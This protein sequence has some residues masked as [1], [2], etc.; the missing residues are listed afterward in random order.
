MGLH[1]LDM[2][3][4]CDWRVKGKKKEL[5]VTVTEDTRRRE[6]ERDG[7]REG[8]RREYKGTGGKMIDWFPFLSILPCSW[9]L[10]YFLFFATSMCV[11]EGV[12]V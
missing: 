11:R 7:R 4:R 1:N 2:V 3:A 10:F 6:G 8:G 9:S 5:T 12:F